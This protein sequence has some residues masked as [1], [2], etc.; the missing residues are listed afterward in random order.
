MVFFIMDG[1]LRSAVGAIPS[2][3]FRFLRAA[4]GAEIEGN[5]LLTAGRAI[6]A[7]IFFGLLRAAIGA[8]VKGD[9]YK[10]FA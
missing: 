1:V 8:K 5:A 4:I 9:T 7:C 6:P 2:G 3:F 10:P